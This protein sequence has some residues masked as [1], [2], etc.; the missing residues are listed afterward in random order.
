MTGAPLA[1]SV[2]KSSLVAVKEN[3][4]RDAE[5]NGFSQSSGEESPVES[6]P[7]F[8]PK[9]VAANKLTVAQVVKQQAPSQIIPGAAVPSSGK[10][11]LKF[12]VKEYFV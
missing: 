6:V 9:M 8:E 7:Q 12:D 2:I 5:K 3:G 11:I 1:V 4:G 10:S